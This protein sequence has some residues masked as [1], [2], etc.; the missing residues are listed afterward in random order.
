MS[1]SAS[2]KYEGPIVGPILPHLDSIGLN[3][4]ELVLATAYYSMRALSS[5]KPKA[6]IVRFFCRLDLRSVDDWV[7]GYTDP[8]CLLSFAKLQEERGADIQLFVS[9]Q[10]HA[11]VYIGEHA[12]LVGSANLT[13][14]GFGGGQ[15]IIYRITDSEQKRKISNA[16]TLYA[17]D[18]EKINIKD[19]H[20]YIEYYKSEV[21]SKR[22]KRK[23]REDRLPS[24]SRSRHAHLGDYSDFKKWL[25]R[26]QNHAANEILQRAMGKSNLSGHINRNFHG[27]RQLF[28]AYPEILEKYSKEKPD[29]YK[30]S[31]DYVTE[32]FIKEFVTKN[33]IDEDT[34]NVEIW[35]TYLPIECGGRA[36]RHGGTIGNLNYMMPLVARYLLKIFKKN[37]L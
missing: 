26:Q 27:L 37:I 21:S 3:G 32:G 10:A 6:S 25:S 13:L 29:G 11:K 31:K 5:L 12:A 15:E 19:L 2:L 18:F 14:R 24:F 23:K 17:K 9:P 30:L 7:E 34:F 35:K 28:L 1:K 8:P 20:D 36:G 16:I 4:T 33:A 22:K